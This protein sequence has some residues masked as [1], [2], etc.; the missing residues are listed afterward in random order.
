M[1]NLAASLLRYFIP[2]VILYH[3]L[4]AADKIHQEITVVITTLILRT[5]STSTMCVSGRI[6]LQLKMQQLQIF[7]IH[8]CSSVTQEDKMVNVSK[9]SLGLSE[10]Q[11][12]IFLTAMGRSSLPIGWLN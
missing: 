11:K 3:C 7:L 1:T 9:I 8:F 12:P 10:D 4:P 2:Q 5:F 6:V